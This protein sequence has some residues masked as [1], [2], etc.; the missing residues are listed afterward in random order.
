MTKQQIED[1]F[2]NPENLITDGVGNL[3]NGIKLI[4]LKT[5]TLFKD[6][7]KKCKEDG[8]INPY[9]GGIYKISHKTY[10]PVLDYKSRVDNNRKKED[11]QGVFTPQNITLFGKE[12]VSG[13]IYKD[14]ETGE[15]RYIMVEWFDEVNH[16]KNTYEFQGQPIEKV[17]FEKWVSDSEKKHH[18]QGVENDVLVLTIDLNNILE[19]SIDGKVHQVIHELPQVV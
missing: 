19:V 15:K 10:R 17:L 14:T 13:C 5:R 4:G 11:V 18:S 2:G 8:T 16:K 6:V 12:K 1:Y 7:R 3:K 9:Y